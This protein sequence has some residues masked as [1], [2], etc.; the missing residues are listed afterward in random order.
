[1]SHVPGDMDARA[2][3][4]GRRTDTYIDKRKSNLSRHNAGMENF[5]EPKDSPL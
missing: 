3:G 2:A 5:H 4:G 1:M